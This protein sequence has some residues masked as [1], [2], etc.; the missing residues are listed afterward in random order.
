MAALS[1]DNPLIV[2]RDRTVLLETDHP[3]Y[4]EARQAL[5]LFA[6]LVKSPEGLH[7]YKITPLSLWNAAAA[8][9]RP[10]QVLASL[11]QF[12]KHPV[13]EQ[14]AAE[15][16]E[17]MGRYG[18]VRMTSLADGDLLIQSDQPADLVAM[19][20][21]GDVAELVRVTPEGLRVE[22]AYRGLIK[23]RA[24]RLGWPIVD[25]AGYV[26]GAPLPLGLRTTT[27]AGRPFSP[28]P[29]QVEAAEAFHAGGSLY[30][31]CGVVV[32]PC[33]AGKTVVGLTVMHLL[34]TQTLILTS[35]VTS[36]RQWVQEI[37]DKTSLG[38]DQVTE[39]TGQHK[40]LADVTVSTYQLM[41]Y[42]GHEDDPFPHLALFQKRDWGLIIYDEV[43][44]LPAPVFRMTAAIQAR[45]RLGLTATLVREDGREEDV[46]SLVG[47]KRY[48]LPWKALETQGFIATAH[49]HE[50]R[51][52]MA[53]EWMLDYS[54]ADAR[55]KARLAAEN[56]EKLRYVKALLERHADD[57]VLI[58][59]QYLD[60]LKRIAAELNAPLITGSTPNDQRDALYAAFRRG[61]TRCLV[62]SKVANFA[63]DLPDAN[64]AIQVS[65]TYGSRQ[66]EAQR[67]GRILRPKAGGGAAHF[68][69]LVTQNSKEQPFAAKRQRFLAEQ[70][71]DYEITYGEQWLG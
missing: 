42:R 55:G 34:Q 45:R 15:I 21:A 69:T 4:E 19:L 1:P 25:L 22:P 6:D 23:Q 29:Y 26:P 71:Y 64:V 18:R 43:H 28:R 57:N 36:V 63:I 62:V 33:G 49:C 37:L 30:G 24:L 20:G 11:N 35:N 54:A 3:R 50:L 5:S 65:G 40:G 68:Y 60:Q 13:P 41:T 7:T 66:E 17:L 32:L 8:G 31:G 51:I 38:P 58:I 61:E 14:A 39:Y 44:L 9:L 47:P 56:P 16:A 53:S 12:A 67:L 46:F 27:R 48:E 10:E 70:G 52:P 2:G 59:G